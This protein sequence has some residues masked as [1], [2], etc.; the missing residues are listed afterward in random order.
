MIS[1]VV[2]TIVRNFVGLAFSEVGIELEFKGKR[3]DEKVYVT[4]CNYKDFQV[5]IS[6]EV[7]SVYPS[8][9]RPTEVDLLTRNSSKAKNKLG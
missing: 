3:V 1:I 5:K 4:K 7:L 2:I 6:K 9:F 8:C